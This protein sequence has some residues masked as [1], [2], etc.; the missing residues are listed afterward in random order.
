[1]T[2]Q[3]YSINLI[4]RYFKHPNIAI[5]LK[6]AIRL[7]IR[8]IDEI[9]LIESNKIDNK[10]NVMYYKA[11]LNDYL[12]SYFNMVKFELL[13]LQEFYNKDNEIMLYNYR[14]N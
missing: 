5:D 3:E 13:E 9:E 1:M 7:S 6:N 10:H 2:P 12:I 8:H 11:K 4:E 14:R